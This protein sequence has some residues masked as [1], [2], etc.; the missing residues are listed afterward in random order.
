MS[1]ALLPGTALAGYEMRPPG[2]RAGVV[3]VHGIGEHGGRYRHVA[4]AFAAHGIASFIYDQRG[5]GQNAGVRTHVADFAEFT[6]DLE[7]VGTAVQR[8]HA[9]LPLF[10]WGHSMGSIVAL[11][12]ALEGLAWSRGVITSGCALDALPSLTGI[13]GV[14]LKLANALVPRLRI[15]LGVDAKRLTQVADA[16]LKHMNDPLVP[17]SA[18]LRLLYGLA[19]ACER[20]ASQLSQVQIPW[21]AIHGDADEV[22]PVSGSQRL[23]AGLGSVDKQLVRYPGLLHEPHN[24]A[25]LSR[26]IM[27]EQMARWMLERIPA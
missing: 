5:H 21:L 13:K 14:G 11:S 7:V 16:Q 3:L 18:S 1:I 12:A 20:C 8:R 9:G 6:Q 19:Q 17:R 27:F 23:I 15:T 25:E 10:V 26:S 22:C 2:A 4:E 24:E